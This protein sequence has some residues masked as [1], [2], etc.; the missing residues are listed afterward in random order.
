[1]LKRTKPFTY[2]KRAIGNIRKDNQS[3]NYPNIDTD[4]CRLQELGNT[5]CGTPEDKW[6][7]PIQEELQN[8]ANRYWPI[9]W[10]ADPSC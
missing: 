3:H 7:A 6:P 8:I 9:T 1:M 5:Y 10:H 2:A 4:E